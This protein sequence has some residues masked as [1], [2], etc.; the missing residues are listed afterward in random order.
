MR[1]VP[2]YKKPPIFTDKWPNTLKSNYYKNEFIK[3]MNYQNI[4]H[5]ISKWYFFKKC[6][7][8][9]FANRMSK[10]IVLLNVTI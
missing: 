4:N 7:T 2:I 8:C 3:K 5:C 6:V 1:T 9:T 10:S